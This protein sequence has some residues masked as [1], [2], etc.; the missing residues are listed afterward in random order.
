MA[1][2]VNAGGDVVWVSRFY[3]AMY[4][5]KCRCGIFVGISFVQGYLYF[6]SNNKDRWSMKAL[7]IFLL[8]FDPATS[9]L[10]AETIY[11]YFVVNFGV[12]EA[13]ETIPISWVIESEST[14]LVTAMVQ[15]FFA[16]RVYLINGAIDALPLRWAAPALVFLFALMALVMGTVRTALLGVWSLRSFSLASYQTLA[17]IEESCALMSDLFASTCLCYMLAPPQLDPMKRSETLKAMFIFTINRAVLMT[18]VQI[19]ML[20]SYLYAREHLYW[21][22]FHLCKSKLYTNTL[23][24]MLNSRSGGSFRPQ[25]PSRTPWSM[26]MIN[27]TVKESGGTVGHSMLTSEE[28]VAPSEAEGNGSDF[29]NLPSSGRS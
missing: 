20:S 6:T 5:G 17:T 11:Y 29:P 25:A 16:T 27:P 22:P 7:V 12:V 28:D 4:W 18:I 19:G 1:T 14:V 21:M 8:I 15:F 26:P 3:S 23:L 2:V 10:M 24:A 9:L 13:L